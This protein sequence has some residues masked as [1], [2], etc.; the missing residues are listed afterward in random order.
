[1]LL[2]QTE[3]MPD[4]G[5]CIDAMPH[6]TALSILLEGQVAAVQSVQEALPQIER[7]AALIAATIRSGSTLVYAAAGSSA[8]MGLA[9]GAELPGTFGIPQNQIRILMAGGV[10][11]DGKMPGD[12]EDDISEALKFV[13]QLSDTDILITLSASGTT[14]YPCEIAKLARTKGIKIIA[15]ANNAGSTLLDLSDVAILLPT[16]PEALAGST[17]L[18]AGTAQK[19]ALNMMST[20]AGVLLGHVHDGLMVNLHADNT[21]LR[22][23]ARDIVSSIANV[24]P[25]AA[26]AALR[27]AR[28]DTKVAVL[29]AAGCAAETAYQL[30]KDHD[31][32]LGPCLSAMASEHAN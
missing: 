9:D 3:V 31:G 12:T 24:A 25:Q 27:N 14:P 5:D 16:P 11:A 23:R 13:N 1:M 28:N 26:E 7:G 21:K 8:L 22:G 29:L 30:L 4:Q 10:P 15:I 20:L 2:P 19:V 6:E 32:H 18:G 17:R